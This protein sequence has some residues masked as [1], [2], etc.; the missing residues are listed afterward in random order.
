MKKLINKPEDVV[1]E[2][3]AGM[4]AAHAGQLKVL[5]QPSYI[6]WADAPVAGKVA[7][8][9]GGGSGH[10]PL[11]G[12]LVLYPQPTDN[13]RAIRSGKIAL[14]HHHERGHRHGIGRVLLSTPHSGTRAGLPHHPC[15]VARSSHRHTAT[16]ST[17][18]TP[19]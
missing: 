4:A 7:L 11:H 2:A 3:L 10:K 14:F 17:R 1:T 12:G 9:S 13:S 16:N 15:L 8:V 18:S 19:T 5:T 6:I